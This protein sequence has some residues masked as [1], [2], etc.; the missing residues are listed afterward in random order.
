MLADRP[1][2]PET[3]DR[4]LEGLYQ[5]IGAATVLIKGE[6]PAT[7]PLLAADLEEITQAVS[8]LR[9]YGDFT[10]MGEEGRKL[11]RRLHVGLGRAKA[12]RH[13]AGLPVYAA[14]LSTTRRA[15]D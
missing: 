9:E 14:E 11:L 4:F 7:L 12:L 6:P 8:R 3:T 10:G 13:L 15:E 1:Y 5:R 2:D